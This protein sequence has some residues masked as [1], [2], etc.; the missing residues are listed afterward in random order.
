MTRI[1]QRGDQICRLACGRQ[2]ELPDS[3]Q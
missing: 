1:L 3:S 2:H